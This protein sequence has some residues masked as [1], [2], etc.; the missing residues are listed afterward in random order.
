[1]LFL[2]DRLFNLLLIVVLVAA[3]SALCLRIDLVLGTGRTERT[4]VLPHLLVLH[5]RKCQLLC[6]RLV[7]WTGDE[8]QPYIFRFNFIFFI[9]GD[10]LQ[11][12]A[13]VH[14]IVVKIQWLQHLEKGHVEN[15][16]S[17]ASVDGIVTD[18]LCIIEKLILA[19]GLEDLA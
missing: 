11:Y 15:L 13:L 3:F 2:V 17:P 1:M 6:L 10:G 12:L 9:V 16:E 4:G 8:I 14:F 5:L 19:V 7:W 18:L